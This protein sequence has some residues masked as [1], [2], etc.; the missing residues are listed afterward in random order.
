MDSN[1]LVKSNTSQ[2]IPIRQ[3]DGSLKII[4]VN[5]LVWPELKL[6]LDNNRPKAVI[7]FLPPERHLGS[8]IL[9]VTMSMGIPLV[10]G[11]VYDLPW[12]VR[13][14]IYSGAT[15]IVSEAHILPYLLKALKKKQALTTLPKL[16]LVSDGHD[17]EFM[18]EETFNSRELEVIHLA[19][20]F[21]QY[22][23]E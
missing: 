22:V 19:N 16:I 9:S 11:S 1:S 15:C 17:D 4:S 10:C 6:V 7:T 3:S 18:P 8:L 23:S 2:L 12:T 5:D 13:A 20:P 21:S 14:Y